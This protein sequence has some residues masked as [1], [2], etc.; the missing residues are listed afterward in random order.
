[1]NTSAVRFV[2]SR[3]IVKHLYVDRLVCH[4]EFV[5]PVY[6]RQY[7]LIGYE[8]RLTNQCENRC[9]NTPRYEKVVL[10]CSVTQHHFNIIHET[11]ESY[12]ERIIVNILQ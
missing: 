5:F 12:N 1:M 2:D 6:F 10:S 4:I 11:I 9:S 8:I 3:V 7:T